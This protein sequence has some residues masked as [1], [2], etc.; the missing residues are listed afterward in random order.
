MTKTFT[1]NLL[2][3]NGDSSL[4]SN[5][6]DTL[7]IHNNENFKE[8][9]NAILASN[10]GT[11][12]IEFISNDTLFTLLITSA[13]IFLVEISKSLI[14]NYTIKRQ[15]KQLRKFIKVHLDKIL[16]YI[17]IIEYKYQELSSQAKVETGIYVLPAKVFMF[18]FK[19]V[20]NS[21][22]R[23]LYKS[24]KEKNKII[25]IVSQ[26][27]SISEYINHSEIYH[28][29][30]F[31]RTEKLQNSINIKYDEFLNSAS[32]FL[33]EF[34]KE[35]PNR[36][37]QMD[38]FK[39]LNEK[40]LIHSKYIAAGTRNISIFYKEI[41]RPILVYI[42]DNKLASES[43][44]ANKILSIARDFSN[45]YFEFDNEIN[46]YKQQFYLFSITIKDIRESILKNIDE[47]NWN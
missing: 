11:R 37:Q 33:E 19:I 44:N 31:T 28:N 39:F 2:F 40:L 5:K 14:Q 1:M 24:F 45:I 27:D 6:I 35:Y 29:R 12:F 36:Y 42:V 9:S 26:L 21:D 18:D 43:Q 22:L 3:L 38:D 16:P 25:N 4:I 17:E 34:R 41:L 20:L 46:A 10:K 15:E 30:A 23:E 13:V 32:I 8:L 7:I 47:L